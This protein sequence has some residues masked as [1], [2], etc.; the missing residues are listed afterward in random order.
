MHGFRYEVLMNSPG[1]HFKNVM[2][3]CYREHLARTKTGL[4][5]WLYAER[6]RAFEGFYAQDLPTRKNES[7]KYTSLAPLDAL[8]IKPYVQDLPVSLALETLPHGVS[9][10]FLKDAWDTPILK[11]SILQKEQD[12]FTLLNTSFLNDGCLVS[13]APGTIIGKPLVLSYEATGTIPAY[14]FLRVIVEIGEGA[15]LTLVEHKVSE[16]NQIIFTNAVTEI[17]LHNESTLN[18]FKIQKLNGADS[19]AISKTS[20]RQK[21]NSRFLSFI[22]SVSA[23]FI[24]NDL[25][26]D[27]QESGCAA[28]LLGLYTVK[29]KAHVDNHLSINHLSSHTE[30]KTTYHGILEDAARAVFNGKISVAQ[31]LKNVDADLHNHNLLLSSQAEIDTKPEL[32]IYSDDVKCTHGATVGQ[33]DEEALFYLMSR[34]IPETDA[35]NMLK[36]AFIEQ[37]RKELPNQEIKKYYEHSI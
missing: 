14:A 26:I 20:V 32:E 21:R 17:R 2:Q 8:T 9:I 12:V 4:P 28:R 24:R 1:A 3:A 15:T 35:R 25:Q 5:S 34:G 11:E 7:W 33:L 30:S 19:I 22:E 36:E 16:N 13:V 6:E 23:R 18:Y 37:I 27:L 29:E 31:H 10:R